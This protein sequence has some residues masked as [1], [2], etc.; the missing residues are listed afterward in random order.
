M[1]C[2]E[3]V[4]YS[5]MEQTSPSKHPVKSHKLKQILFILL[6]I[7]LLVTAIYRSI[8]DDGIKLAFNVVFP[9]S[10]LL[11]ILAIISFVVGYKNRSGIKRWY[12][13]ALSIVLMGIL[14]LWTPILKN[15]RSVLER[16]IRWESRC[17]VVE[18]I[19]SKTLAHS[20]LIYEKEDVKESIVIV[21]F[22]KYGRVSFAEAYLYDNAVEVKSSRKTGYMIIFT[23]DGGFFGPKS[24]LIYVEK[25]FP[26]NSYDRKIDAHWYIRI[27][28]FSL[29]SNSAL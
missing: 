27:K 28:Q 4:L 1:V 22:E 15:T 8:Y 23:T 29:F 26:D 17:K 20:Y 12:A 16:T 18:D 19:K 13:Y 21:P 5:R 25:Q 6:T 3:K 10:F 11:L 7:L 9:F 14:V 2:K 24:Q